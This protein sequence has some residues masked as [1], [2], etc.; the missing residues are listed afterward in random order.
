MERSDSIV[1]LHCVYPE[2]EI[3]KRS[4]LY[5]THFSAKFLPSNTKQEIQL[6]QL[7]DLLYTEIN[8]I[9]YNMVNTITKKISVIENKVIEQGKSSE[10][11]R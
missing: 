5:S 2:C 1:N 8:I 9:Q 4:V 11:E 6:A 10:R 7:A 3:G